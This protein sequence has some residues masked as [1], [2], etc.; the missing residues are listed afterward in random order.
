MTNYHTPV[1]LK[2]SID[3]LAIKPDGVYVDV[4]FG[5]GGHSREIL[6][7]LGPKGKLIGFDRDEDAGKNLIDDER[8]IFVA[9][10]FQFI[11]HALQERGLAPVDGILA[12]LGVSSY[13]LDTPERGFSYRFD[14]PLDMRM[15]RREGPT[16]AD[17]LNE[18]SEEELVRIFRTYGEIPNNRKLVRTILTAREITPILQTKQFEQ[19]IQ[20]CLPRNRQAKYLAQV[21]QA[22]RI[23]V[24]GE[25]DSLASLLESSLNLL[26]PGGHFVVIAYHSLEDRM[27]KHFFRSGNL[28]GKEV[29]DH[30][31]RLLTPWEKITRRPV[32][33]TEEEV[34]RNPRARS[35][36]LRAAKRIEIKS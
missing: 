20:S 18:E 30:F 24:N 29:K 3:F 8:L 2:E 25:M 22:L 28:A 5:G 31:G 1:L 4:T 13:Q 15:N 16:A 32:Q 26:K 23:E 35:A 27:V 21:Y 36:R 10:D 11:E 19:N 34:N 7:R 33:A 14:G 17:L 6:K 9:E 12:D